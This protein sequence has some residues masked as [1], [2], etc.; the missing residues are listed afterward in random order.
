M[1]TR[2]KSLRGAQGP[3]AGSQDPEG[4]PQIEA[5]HALPVHPNYRL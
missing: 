1:E 2:G 4:E 5:A 3:N